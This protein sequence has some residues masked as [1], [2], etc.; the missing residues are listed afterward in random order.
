[1][2][3]IVSVIFSLTIRLFWTSSTMDL[4]QNVSDIQSNIWCYL[5]WGERLIFRE[6]S[7][8]CNKMHRH[9]FQP[10]SQTVTQF[11]NLSLHIHIIDPYNLIDF[12]LERR[13]F[14]YFDPSL[15]NER[16][17]D[18]HESMMIEKII[19]DITEIAPSFVAADRAC[20]PWLR[21]FH[22]S[23]PSFDSNRLHSDRWPIVDIN[24]S[25][26]PC[27]RNVDKL[28]II[29]R[30]AKI[31]MNLRKSKYNRYTRF[32]FV[33]LDSFLMSLDTIG[34]RITYSNQSV[35]SILTHLWNDI[36]SVEFISDYLLRP[37]LLKFQGPAIT[38]IELIIAD[39]MRIRDSLNT[40]RLLL[41]V[42]H[43]RIL[44]D[45]DIIFW[46][47]V[48][49]PIW[50]EKTLTE[51]LQFIVHHRLISWTQLEEYMREYR[52]ANPADPIIQFMWRFVWYRCLQDKLVIV[53]ESRELATRNDRATNNDSSNPLVRRNPTASTLI[54]QSTP[55]K[56]ACCHCM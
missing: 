42:D 17:L 21:L 48:E 29:F 1:M 28:Y 7:T 8:S 30:I 50:S 27:D 20:T 24:G 6:V 45:F 34:P 35:N 38:A 44:F 52:T 4:V 53:E 5:T 26:V 41:M 33:F 56:H 25:V 23:F 22:D 11:R 37:R 13:Y 18:A 15:F 49:S 43:P 14:N 10:E 3:R 2:D 19:V 36:V 39:S 40:D 32:A 47:L 55:K 16:M 54:D 46:S 51:S 31:E 9:L 12:F